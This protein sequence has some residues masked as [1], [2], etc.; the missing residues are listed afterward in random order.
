MS[1]S[2][3]AIRKGFEYQDLVCGQSLLK[4]IATNSFDLEFSLE[5]EDVDHIDDLVVYYD[6]STVLATQ[7]KFH[8]TQDYAESFDTLTA[9][10]TP[11]SSSL[12][13]KI[14]KGW[15]SLVGS[16]Y[17]KPSVKFISSNPAE[18][19]R[20]KLGPVM[21]STSGH[22]N[23]KFFDHKDYQTPRQ[24]FLSQLGLSLPE[25]REFL[26]CVE[27][28]FSNESIDSVRRD[29][30]WH[31][32]RINL[33]SDD[34]AVSRYLEVIGDIANGR[35]G[36]M[37]L[38]ALVQ[39]LWATS[40]FRDSCERQFTTIDFGIKQLRRANIGRVAVV[41]LHSLAAFAGNRYACL[42]EP[43]PFPDFRNGITAN[44]NEG[45]L[46][47]NRKS[48]KHEYV[49]WQTARVT[50]LLMQLSSQQIDLLVFPRFVLPLQVACVV[51]DWCREN[52]CHLVLGG[53]SLPLTETEQELY[54]TTLNIPTVVALVPTGIND[55]VVDAFVRYD[56][57]GRASLS[58][59]ESPF[60]KAEELQESPESLQLQFSDGWIS[61]V[62][63]ASRSAVK[64]FVAS[65][66]ARPELI[67]IAGGVHA[68]DA[69]EELRTSALLT[70]VPVVL[71]SS[72]A[73]IVPTSV[74]L[75]S[76][77]PHVPHSDGW[78][79]IRVFSI[80]YER[81]PS[82]WIAASQDVA[83]FPL[84]YHSKGTSCTEANYE[85]LQG[86]HR[87]RNDAILLLQKGAS[88]NVINCESESPP[89]FYLRRAK[90]AADVVRGSLA[91]ASPPQIVAFSKTL[92]AISNCIEQLRADAF[93]PQDYAPPPQAIIP[94]RI[95]SFFNRS[96]EKAEIGRVLSSSSSKSVLL[97]HG[98]AGIGKRELVTEVQR[99]QPNRNS[100]IRFRCPPESLLVETLCQLLVR[101]GVTSDLPTIA[102]LETF[103]RL[104]K[105]VADIGIPVIILEDAHCL[106]ISKDAQDHTAFLELLGFWCSDNH[107][108]TKLVLL[109]DWKGHLQF[110]GS[111]R[112]HPL[113]IQELSD[114]YVVEILQ[115][116]LSYCPCKHEPPTIEE[117]FGLAARLHGHPFIARLAAVALQES[118]I[119]DVIGRIYSRT[120]TRSF[121]LGRLMAGIPISGHE[122]RLLQYA[123]LHRMPVYADAFI[124][125]G[126]PAVNTVVEQLSD[127]FLVLSEA[128]RFIL[129][130]IL[131]D[132][133]SSSIDSTQDRK[134]LHADAFAYYSKL[135]NRKTLSVEERTEYVYH[136]VSAGK[137]LDMSDMQ[138]FAG[139]MRT[140]LREAVRNKDWSGAEVAAYHL[141]S[142]WPCDLYG[143]IGMALALDAT[144]RDTEAAQYATSLEHVGQD[145]LW[146]ALEFVKSLITRRDYYGAERNLA[147]I[148]QQF[149]NDP[150]VIIAEAQLLERQGRTTEA[151][152]ACEGVLSTPEVRD[153]DAFLAALILR[154]ANRL[155]LLIR[156]LERAY[157]AGRIRNDG[158]LRLYSLASVTAN[159]DPV[160]GL[161][162]LSEMWQ[163][164]PDD[165]FT[166]A[167]YA[168]ALIETGRIS[169]AHAVLQRGL[170]E[171]P[172]ASKGYR[173]VLD[174]DA[175][176]FERQERFVEAFE[177]YREA[178]GRYQNHLHIFRRFARC[179]LAAAA[180]YHSSNLLLQ[181]DSAVAEAKQVLERLLQMAP[182]DN[183]ASDMLHKAQ[184][185]SY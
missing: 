22:F 184:V 116:H 152:L 30:S 68:V 149:P 130:P 180:S 91:K 52:K 85:Q 78:E 89:Q 53:H 87:S 165:G 173:Q 4:L 157:E 168:T 32:K 71:A 65:G 102:N 160:D 1:L 139:S 14:Y 175:L 15:S 13:Q 59:M 2:P 169:D 43:F 61:A 94:A 18:R 40:R 34:D 137:S 51:A 104:S 117:L 11:K 100:W 124:E 125:Y 179:L 161:Q 132:Y 46:S 84:C 154:D 97:I 163:S 103:S 81:I 38:R 122:K 182:L 28:K 44:D 135:K 6:H 106:P 8:V 133:F 3:Y 5:S 181:E 45:L 95:L 111:H 147:V 128:D 146:I 54:E 64:L 109:T 72:E 129:H 39:Q 136:G 9:K 31:L 70:G 98:Q 21:N 66:Q 17:L 82:G 27:W 99:I 138:M 148:Q 7:V 63:L 131:R 127:R 150:R 60:A 145:T 33:P 167:D 156:H 35:K 36:K 120:E 159:H 50:R 155:D 126:G 183:W 121:V 140:A 151:V 56:R 96:T 141:L 123:S 112:M 37:S 171:V 25:L 177:R 69:L 113:P 158:L 23:D 24:T 93:A 75:D 19:G 92:E 101:C 79:G 88:N 77:A 162:V 166:V 42:E 67:V 47:L 55:L 153:R 12:I 108:R 57:A 134:S 119:S 26:A 62:Q 83:T 41:S 80:S 178:T 164:K 16:G 118:S 58:K 86:L 170:D 49:E 107:P 90:E 114:E 74:I 10:K 176:L 73:H 76:H 29:I 143:Q 105:A 110:S 20:Y 174:A 48:W 142:I 144:G 185:R 115:E 172:P